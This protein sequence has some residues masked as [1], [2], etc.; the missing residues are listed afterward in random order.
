MIGEPL[1]ASRDYN[2]ATSC[3]LRA[4]GIPFAFWDADQTL[5]HVTRRARRAARNTARRLLC[6]KDPGPCLHD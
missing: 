3:A 4:T 6:I 2:M 5:L 1:S